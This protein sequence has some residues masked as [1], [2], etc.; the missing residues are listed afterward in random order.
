MTRMYFL[1]RCVADRNPV[2]RGNH[3]SRHTFG[4]T[5]VVGVANQTGTDVQARERV[6][7]IGRKKFQQKSVLPNPDKS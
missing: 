2:D 4:D 5:M 7:L 3:W 1:S 6:D